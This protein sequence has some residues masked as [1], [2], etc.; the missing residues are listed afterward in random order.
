V[1]KVIRRSAS[2]SN[3]SKPNLSGQIATILIL[4]MVAVLIFVLAIVNMGKISITATTLANA[5]DSA[6]LSLGSQLAT[7]ANVLYNSIPGIEK[8]KKSSWLSV[9]LAIVFAIIVVIVGYGTTWFASYG[10]LVAA[11][12]GA[13]G[14]AIGAAISG[15][16]ILT[17]ALQGA[18]IGAAIG[19]GAM[20]GAE[21]GVGAAGESAATSG[22]AAYEAGIAAGMTEAAA[23]EFAIDVAV[24][25]IASASAVG[26]TIGV[27]VVAGCKLYNASV[28][29]KMSSAAIAAASKALNGLPEYERFQEGTMLQ[30][31]SLVVDDPNMVADSPDTDTD[32]DTSE[33]VSAFQVWWWNRTEAY[34][35][36]AATMKTLTDAFKTALA[37]FKEYELYTVYQD[38]SGG[39]GCVSV[40]GPFCRQEIEGGDGS[41]IA[42]FRTLESLRGLTFWDSGPSQA[43][44]NS[45]LA[46]CDS[47]ETCTDCGSPPAGYDYVDDMILELQ[48]FSDFSNAIEQQ[49]SYDLVGTYNSWF[50]S[51]YDPSQTGDFYDKLQE[52]RNNMLSWSSEIETVRQSLEVCTAGNLDTEGSGACTECSEAVVWPPCSKS[53]VTNPPCRGDGEDFAA[54]FGTLNED[55]VDEFAAAQATL[56]NVISQVDTVMAAIQNYYN[57]MEAAT[58][59]VLGGV[60]PATY[61]WSDSLGSHSVAV[62]AGSYEV[63]HTETKTS[64]SWT[65]KTCIY[66][67]H[68]SGSTSVSVSRTDPSGG[69]VG[70]LGTWNRSGGTISRSATVS[71]NGACSEHGGCYVRLQ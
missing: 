46:A 20:M 29:D 22:Q 34:R 69:A 35:S 52:I 44:L 19:G 23:G 55:L 26:A 58:G 38:C 1:L 60:N 36:A 14:G 7:K 13:I 43:A 67:R 56:S 4:M 45:W 64:G 28:A 54:S 15:T 3:I 40:Y 49:D 39:Y 57:Q 30:A 5:A 24:S 48:N 42:F 6:A 17:G 50:P 12:A 41:L 10:I 47:C 59:D 68:Y 71:Y 61:T 31:F 62:T 21:I 27:V 2:L 66:L 51:F 65:K 32:G 63:P 16:N 53:C 8:C 33:E 25:C 18:I 9:I 11:L 70:V 37:D